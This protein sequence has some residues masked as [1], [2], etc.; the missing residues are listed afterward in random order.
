MAGA[1][2]TSGKVPLTANFSSAGSYDPDGDIAGYAWDFGDGNIVADEANPSHAYTEPGTYIAV[3]T[4]TDGQG[5]IATAQ[6]E[7][8]ARKSKGTGNR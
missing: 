6:V 7:I 5:L 8:L 3:L 2:V 4:V 1:D